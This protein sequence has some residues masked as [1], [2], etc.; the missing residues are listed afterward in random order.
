[1]KARSRLRKILLRSLGAIVAL[2]VLGCVVLSIDGLHDRLGKA[3]LGLVLGSKVELDGKPSLRLRARLD[4]TLELYRAGHFPDVIVSGGM[5][6]EGFDE[7]KVM[8]DYLVSH[9][10]PPEHI[11][12]DSDGAT[13]F[14]SAQ[15]TERI[16]SQRKATSVLAISQ[17]FHLPR[18][19]LA[20]HRCGIATVYTAHAHWFEVRDFYSVPREV[21]GYVSYA[22]RHF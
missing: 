19:R 22:L 7:A 21:A 15:N 5:G 2:W 9:G 17:Y 4:R 14:A 20:L 13:T 3:D 10:I 8:R 11:I 12:V 6:K 18:T 16:V 1:M